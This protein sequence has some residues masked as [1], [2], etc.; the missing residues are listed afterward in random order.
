MA[1]EK[2]IPNEKDIIDEILRR[3]GT[4]QKRIPSEKDE[5]L[6]GQARR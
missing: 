3:K 4:Q 5:D 1:A 6:Q 2:T